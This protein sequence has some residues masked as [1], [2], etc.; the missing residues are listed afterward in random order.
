MLRSLLLLLFVLVWAGPARAE[1]GGATIVVR[2][3][4]PKG[5]VVAGAYVSAWSEASRGHP[6]ATATSDSNGMAVLADVPAGP[7]ELYASPKETAQDAQQFTQRFTVW[8][9][10]RWP[11][12]HGV[13]AGELVVTRTESWMGVCTGCEMVEVHCPLRESFGRSDQRSF[14]DTRDRIDSAQ[15]QTLP[16]SGNLWSLIE[17]AVPAAVVDRIDGPGLYLGDPGR[18]AM[19]GSSW[20]QDSIRLGSL[21]ITDGTRGGTP[22]AYP[23]VDALDAIDITSALAPVEYGVPGVTLSLKPREPSNGWRGHVQGSWAGSGLQAK[24]WPG[25]APAIARLGSLADA[26]GLVSGPIAGQKLRVLF[27]A[28]ASRMQRFERAYPDELKAE[29]GSVFGH[30]VYQASDR[31]TL[32]LVTSA[33]A[34]D[35]PFAGRARFSDRT[36]DERDDFG[37]A[38]LKWDHAGERAT[39]S[40]FAGFQAGVLRPQT[41]GRVA[42]QPIERLLD[43][44]VP[45][46]AFAGR[47]RR[48]TWSAG[49]SMGLAA[50]RVLG[51]WHALRLGATASGMSATDRPD[52][53]R[54]TAELV[55]G[56]A[57]RVW[58]YGYAGESRRHTFDLGAYAADRITFRDRFFLEAGLRLDSTSGSAQGAA[59]GINWT[60]VSPRVSARLRL[61]NFGRFSLIGGYGEY[62]HRL[63]L[64]ALAFGDPAAPQGSVYRWKDPNGNGVFDP[65]ERGVLVAR[66]GPG[67]PDGQF[68]TIDPNLKPPRTREFVVGIESQP[69]R[70]WL[71]SLTG[72]D[73][74][75]R[76]LIESV[77]VGVPISSYN[78]SYVSDPAGDLYGPQD[79]Q[80]LPIYSRK[81]ASFGLDRYVLTN[82]AGDTSKHQGLEFRLQKR[83]GARVTLLVG[84]LAYLSEVGGANRGFRVFENDQGVIGERYDDP[85]VDRYAFGRSF[86]DRAF[87]IKV[88]GSVDAGRGWRFGT[89]ARYQDGQP[90]TR[91]V[92]AP[93]VA[94]GVDEI[95]ATPRGQLVMGPGVSDTQ[96]RYIVPSGHRFTFTMTWDGRVEK[97]FRLGRQ[98][99][100]LSADA[101]NLLGLHQEVEED[102]VTGPA[103]RT[104]TAVQ[105]PRAFRLGAR[106]EF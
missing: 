27:S 22:L 56:Q 70:G 96:G 35:K 19:R 5:A 16:S 71:V 29:V 93:D 90:F 25:D 63:P 103:F 26:G 9:T 44:P 31:D 1:V 45:E 47:S 67:S 38:Q 94:Q 59:Q 86:F 76:D 83:F 24:P 30:L 4:D 48:T 28:R 34:V 17:T 7:V 41:D 42:D 61:T 99:L 68:S 104:P 106:L 75:E 20:T 88:S 32:R 105:P 18:F 40:A 55:D 79:D 57:A 97:S 37:G 73:R 85:N 60:T 33:Q 23:D 82:P 13:A 10:P 2:V 102:V 11:G 65:N 92:I 52:A 58:D 95:P 14:W 21:D 98:R 50:R 77:N 15:Q 72:F 54:I 3:T 91:V 12:Q 78:V 84:A 74:R 62:R 8:S 49:A 87:E 46:L 80:M 100:A 43:G 66:V 69:G 89:V 53:N 81:P 36:V 51:T 101:F 64:D 6:S 39:L